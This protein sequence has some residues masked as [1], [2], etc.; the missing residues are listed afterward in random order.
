[1]ADGPKVTNI[2]ITHLGVHVG[3]GEMA[4]DGTL[5]VKLRVRMARE[6]QHCLIANMIK[7]I[8]LSP[9]YIPAIPKPREA[10]ENL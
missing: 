8:E 5:T 9:A 6:L 10:E 1:M 7:S 4:S 3:H 2:P